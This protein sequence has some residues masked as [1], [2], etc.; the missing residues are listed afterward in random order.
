MQFK[1]PPLISFMQ[2]SN[3]TKCWQELLKMVWSIL[4]SHCY[5]SNGYTTC[6]HSDKGK[7]KNPLTLKRTSTCSVCTDLT[8]TTHSKSSYHKQWV[9]GWSHQQ[10]MQFWKPNHLLLHEAILLWTRDGLKP[11]RTETVLDF[12]RPKAWDT[13]IWFRAF[14]SSQILV[15][16]LNP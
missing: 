5:N 11:L 4:T 2:I 12:Q 13:E 7:N 10:H 6:D 16:I 14:N 3:S 8:A 9:M 15:G 1:K